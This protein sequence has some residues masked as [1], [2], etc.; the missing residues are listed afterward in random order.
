[1]S[2]TSPGRDVKGMWLFGEITGSERECLNSGV[3]CEN[4]MTNFEIFLEVGKRLLRLSQIRKVQLLE[5]RNTDEPK[6]K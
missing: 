3:Q 4:N 5:R 2:D 1:M 6:K